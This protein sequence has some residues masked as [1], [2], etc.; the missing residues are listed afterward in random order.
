MKAS[1]LV[2]ILRDEAARHKARADLLPI[3]EDQIPYA[4]SD[5]FRDLAEAI[6]SQ[7]EVDL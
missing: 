4:I 7:V 1:T 2:N 6:D 3:G 5:A